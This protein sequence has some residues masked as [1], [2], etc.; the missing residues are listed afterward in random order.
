MCPVTQLGV[1]VTRNSEPPC[2]LVLPDLLCDQAILPV[3][4][5]KKGALEIPSSDP[6]SLTGKWRMRRETAAALL[7]RQCAHE[8]CCQGP[9]ATFPCPQPWPCHYSNPIQTSRDLPASLAPG[10]LL[11]SLDSGKWDNKVGSSPCRPSLLQSHWRQRFIPAVAKIPAWN[12]Q[13]SLTYPVTGA[14]E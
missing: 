6:P 13:M 3:P 10:R 12:S 8:W 11:S 7:L 9:Q 2:P 5:V 4:R 14:R 1:W